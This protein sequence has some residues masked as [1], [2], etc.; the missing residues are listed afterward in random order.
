MEKITVLKHEY[1]TA[2]RHDVYPAFHTIIVESSRTSLELTLS[3]IEIQV[4]C[5]VRA[6]LPVRCFIRA[7]V[8]GCMVS[9]MES[10][11]VPNVAY[12]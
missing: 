7:I 3:I 12:L 5:E 9:L 11:R 10:D 4:E 2:L 6:F 1:T 8:V